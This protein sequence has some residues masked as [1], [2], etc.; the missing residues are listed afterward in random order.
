MK[1]KDRKL[2]EQL[3]HIKGSVLCLPWEGMLH[4]HPPGRNVGGFLFLFEASITQVPCSPQKAEGNQSIS[5]HI[6]RCIG[7]VA[8][9]HTR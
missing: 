2:K 6:N 5:T 1:S 4:K 8:I 9:V 7:Q 3:D